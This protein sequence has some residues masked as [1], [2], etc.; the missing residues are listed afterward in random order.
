MMKKLMPNLLGNF[1][2]FFNTQIGTDGDVYLWVALCI[3]LRKR[4][5]DRH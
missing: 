2:A 1:V 4:V 5:G 3:L